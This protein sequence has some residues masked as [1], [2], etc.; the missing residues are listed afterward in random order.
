MT[1]VYINLSDNINKIINVV[2]IR[3]GL[4]TK[5]EAIEYIVNQYQEE[6]FEIS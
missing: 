6:I 3:E 5:S 4:K 1:Q 2:K